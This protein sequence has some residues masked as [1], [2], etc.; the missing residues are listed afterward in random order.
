MEFKKRDLLGNK[1]A[2][3]IAKYLREIGDEDAAERMLARGVSGQSVRFRWGDDAWGHTGLLMG[4][5]PPDAVGE[6]IEIQDA[7]ALAPDNSL[8]GSRI[9]ITLERFWVHSYPGLGKHT[10]LCEFTGKNQIQGE[11][12][13]LRFALTTQAKDK[14]SAPVNGAPIFLGVSVGQNGISFEGRTINVCSDADEIL[15]GALGSGPFR[16][17]LALL[18]TAQPA[19]KPFVGLAG[20]LVSSVLSRS[21]NKPIYSFKLGLDFEKSR[22]SAKLRHGSFL[23]IQGDES[24][25]L[26]KDVVWNANSQQLIRRDDISTLE[27]NYLV[28]RVSAYNDI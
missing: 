8:K 3:T 9:K 22:T 19:L 25:W 24:G 17:G 6:R 11:S 15:L 4:F 7:T 1:P 12:E 5:I 27:Y 13:E 28:F 14:S 16:D 23:V 10:V 18:T 20:S 2:N 26:W 21:K